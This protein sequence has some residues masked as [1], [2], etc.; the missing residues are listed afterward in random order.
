MP[1]YSRFK[2]ETLEKMRGQAFSQYYKEAVRPVSGFKDAMSRIT[3]YNRAVAK[4]EAIDA[5][6][7]KRQEQQTET[8][9]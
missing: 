3:E 8:R 7:M 5:E 4:L 1:D 9:A 2:T 6:L